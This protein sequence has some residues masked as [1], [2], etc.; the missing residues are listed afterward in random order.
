MK[1]QVDFEQLQSVVKVL[2]APEGVQDIWLKA[3]RNGLVLTTD[4]RKAR[5]SLKIPAEVA[6]PGDTYIGI[7][8]L[9][10][11]IDALKEIS[12]SMESDKNTLHLSTKD[13]SG[14][15]PVNDGSLFPLPRGNGDPCKKATWDQATLLTAVKAAK[16]ATGS[17]EG[18]PYTKGF[19]ITSNPTAAYLHSTD[20]RQ[21]ICRKFLCQ[22][23]PME[24][25]VDAE[26]LENVA[27]HSE[28]KLEVVGSDLNVRMKTSNLLC[29]LSPFQ[30]NMPSVREALMNNLKQMTVS[31]ELDAEHLLHG[32]NLVS[33]V[34]DR[35]DNFWCYLDLSP[36]LIRLRCNGERIDEID[37]RI[38]GK[39][40]HSLFIYISPILMLKTLH[41]LQ[42]ENCFPQNIRFM[43]ESQTSPLFFPLSDDNED[44]YA[45]T[46][47]HGP[48]HQNA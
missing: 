4:S 8:R 17:G 18:F 33:S 16:I 12:I 44:F 37:L 27:K 1:C 28:D 34:A 11:Y 15:I 23:D 45:V 43:T 35:R 7:Q 24:F 14:H 42:K 6:D 39:C 5:W 48:S 31:T 21:F 47:L 13:L 10:A 36:S 20:R 3:G 40:T 46:P 41:H 19:Y 25:T 2:S 9:T 26:Q 30:E 32:L 38:P 22:G 29:D